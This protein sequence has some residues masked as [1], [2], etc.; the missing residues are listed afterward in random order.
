M[1]SHNYNSKNLEQ[2]EVPYSLCGV[3]CRWGVVAAGGRTG[4]DTIGAGGLAFAAPEA[5]AAD[6]VVVVVVEPAC[7]PDT[8]S[9]TR[10]R[11]Q[12]FGP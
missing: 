3:D 12:A 11:I 1:P 2:F 6:V 8:V 10:I 5:M 9:T 7:V 4:A